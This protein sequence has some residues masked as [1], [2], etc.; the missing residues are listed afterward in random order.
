MAMLDKTKRSN[1]KLDASDVTEDAQYFEYTSSAN[2]MGAKL[3]SRVPY[4]SFSASLY[5]SGETRVVPLDL[6][7]ELGCEGPATGPGLSANFIRVIANEKVALA[8]NATSLVFYVVDGSGTASQGAT[9]FTFAK[10]DFF[11]FPGGVT[12]ELAAESTTRL[13][14]VNDAPLL[15][16]MGASVNGQRFKPTHYPAT[17]AQEEL[18]KVSHAAG[19]RQRNRVSILLGNANF[20]QTRTVTHTLWAMFGVVAPNT[21][22][23][24]HRHQSIAL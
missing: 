8:P 6:S 9:A 1:L 10:G 22:Q 19:A 13:Y 16:Y 11:T 17:R 21:M 24:P 14:Y 7:A 2:P 15:A 4:R 23:K 5:D 3:I 18:V 20:P 12:L